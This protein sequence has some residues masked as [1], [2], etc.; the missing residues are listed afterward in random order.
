[1]KKLILLLV[2]FAVNCYSQTTVRQYTSATS[3]PTNCQ[4]ATLWV[5]T[6]DNGTF[7]YCDN[8]VYRTIPTVSSIITGSGA[9]GRVAVWSGAQTQTG[10]SSFF[11]DTTTGALFVTATDANPSGTVDF[12]GNE[13][14][15]NKTGAGILTEGAGIFGGA[16][17]D[18]GSMTYLY[19]LGFNAGI[20]GSA[21][22]T[23]TYGI[24]LLSNFDTSSGAITNNYGLKINDQAS[25][26][27]TINRA[28]STG[29]GN[30]I[31]GDNVGIGVVT[32]PAGL[33]HVASNTVDL[34]QAFFGQ[35]NASTD[36]YD[37]NFRKSR[38]T[39]A[40]PTVIT[41]GDDLGTIN[42]RGYTDA[43]NGFV[44]GARIRADSTGTIA[45]NRV[46]GIIAF[47]T[48]TDVTPCVLTERAR[49]VPNGD[50]GIG[51]TD[52]TTPLAANFTNTGLA[53][54]T[55]GTGVTGIVIGAATNS[56][57]SSIRF[58]DGGGG[59]HDQGWLV[60]NHTADSMRLGTNR[61]ERLMILSTGNVG[62]ADST[63]AALF[64]VGNG[65]LFQVNSVGHIVSNTTSPTI[66]SGFGT[67]PAIAGKDL[68]FRVTVGTGGIATTGTVTFGAAW[69]TNAPVCNC[70]N[71]STIL[72]CQAVPTT[73][74]VALNSSVAFTAGDVLEVNCSVGY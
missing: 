16:Y 67:D 9:A 52:P 47:D 14:Y 8:G 1:M 54:G 66:A 20:Q 68:A 40:S 61:T 15:L 35:H 19:G 39:L 32:T 38:G 57:L 51:T 25:I 74:N 71:K 60:Y 50:V 29:T 11:R 21:S 43:T 69:T 62:I 73:T 7:S 30:N 48:C 72:L 22:A 13:F 23:N 41:S 3:P 2:V 27:S 63:P 53:V 42:F 26:G 45:D 49:I 44:I 28:I 12:I 18:D 34:G 6:V 24:L 55:P 4:T 10:F 64:T 58:S 59:N 56:T 17:I 33:L 46:P 65:D 37:V 5:N 31:F 36:A 70:N